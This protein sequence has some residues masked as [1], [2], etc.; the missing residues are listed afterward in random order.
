MSQNNYKIIVTGSAGFIGASLCIK[1]LERGDS[2][3]GIDNHS[4][5]YD[6]KIKE[7]RLKS[8]EK[9]QNY[10]HYKA[11]ICDQKNLEDISLKI[12]L[13][14]LTFIISALLLLNLHSFEQMIILAPFLIASLIKF[15]PL[16]LVPF[17]AKKI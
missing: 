16:F 13:V 2:I 15:S 9:Y 7:E 8:L 11:D 1:L 14:F 6:P 12:F 4:D 5:Y 3:I 10:Q 17:K